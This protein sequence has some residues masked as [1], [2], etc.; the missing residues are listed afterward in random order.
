ML[1]PWTLISP[2]DHGHDQE[3]DEPNEDYLCP[4]PGKL[5][6][7][8]GVSHATLVKLVSLLEHHAA[9]NGWK[10]DADTAGISSG[11]FA[12]IPASAPTQN[13]AGAGGTNT[14]NPIF[15]LFKIANGNAASFSSSFS[16]FWLR[17]VFDPEKRRQHQDAHHKLR[18]EVVGLLRAYA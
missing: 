3:T 14:Q 12:T 13:N 10:T 15:F 4:R 1:K 6:T 18:Y 2:P 11:V 7:K 5:L 17:R 9:L 16:D 8:G